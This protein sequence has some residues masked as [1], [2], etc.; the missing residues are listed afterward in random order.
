MKNMIIGDK[1]C[2]RE[3]TTKVRQDKRIRAK[4]AQNQDSAGSFLW[5]PWY[6]AFWPRDLELPPR[7]KPVYDRPIYTTSISI[8]KYLI[9][10]KSFTYQRLISRCNICK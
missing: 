3:I 2:D 6:G 9:M 7:L 4:L 5:L 8:N 10:Q 1:A